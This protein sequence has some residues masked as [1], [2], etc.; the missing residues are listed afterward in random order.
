MLGT[1]VSINLSPGERYENFEILASLGK[2]GFGTVYKVADARYAEPLA[3]KLS[4]DPIV[5]NDAARRALR[6]VTVLRTLTNPYVVSIL[7]CGLN[8][9]G[10]IFVLMEL[11]R[12]QPLDE[13]HAF[14]TQMAPRWACHIIYQTCLALQEAHARGIVHRDLKPSNVFIDEGGHA[15]LLDFGLARSWDEDSIVGRSATVGHMLVGTPHYAQPEQIVT[16]ELTPAADVYSL[17]LMLYELLSGFTPFDA[18]MRV[19]EIVEAWFD[20]PMKWLRAHAQAELI[21]L[22]SRVGPEVSDDLIRVVESCMAKEPSARPQNAKALG[23]MLRQVW[24]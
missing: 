23:E 8:R 4:H 24:P 10:H 11:L 9:D 18:Q 22:R 7:D 1:A 14:G 6:E 13:F 15:K 2:G 12:G 19:P 17:G 20:N 3:L 21:P 16:N 5:G